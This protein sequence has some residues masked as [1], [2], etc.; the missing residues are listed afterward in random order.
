MPLSR[1]GFLA[2][3]LHRISPDPLKNL[4]WMVGGTCNNKPLTKRT[5]N[6]HYQDEL[7]WVWIPF[8]K[9]DILRRKQSIVPEECL[10]APC[11][12]IC[13]HSEP[14][15]KLI[16]VAIVYMG[17]GATIS[18]CPITSLKNA[19][20]ARTG[21]SRKRVLR[22]AHPIQKPTDANQMRR[23]ATWNHTGAWETNRGKAP[24]EEYT[25][26]DKFHMQVWTPMCSDTKPTK[27]KHIGT[28]PPA[29]MGSLRDCGIVHRGKTASRDMNSAHSKRNALTTAVGALDEQ[30]MLM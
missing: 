27:C 19:S 4:L 26:K 12:S 9:A 8:T 6:L 29:G 11:R 25:C 5:F 21:V 2:R 28:R 22:S 7:L 30:C 16:C 1:W 3:L 15:P 18:H 20:W 14:P 10:R 23:Q 17:G 13:N 24:M